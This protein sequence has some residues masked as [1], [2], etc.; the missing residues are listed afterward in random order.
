MGRL[1]KLLSLPYERVGY[2]ALASVLLGL[3][4]RKHT[5]DP[6][7][8]LI[9]EIKA[10]LNVNSPTNPMLVA[11]IAWA[12]QTAAF[13]VPWRADCL[14]RAIAARFWAQRAGL[15]FEFHLGVSRDPAGQLEAHAWTKSGLALLS[16]GI[17]ELSRFKEFDLEHLPILPVQFT[18]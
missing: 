5:R 6:V 17:P 11:E 15:P 4:R 10:P 8:Q 1:N 9:H 14:V 2:L 3:A 12:L 7:A 13:R 16:G 18:Q